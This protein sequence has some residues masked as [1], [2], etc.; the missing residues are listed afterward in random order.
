MPEYPQKTYGAFKEYALLIDFSE[1][2]D[3]LAIWFF[4]GLQEAAPTLFQKWQ[5][6][7]I[8]EIVKTNVVRL[9]HGVNVSD[10]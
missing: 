7:Q 5:A 4:K 9:R 1:N 10:W 3:L 6:G 2:S 8:A